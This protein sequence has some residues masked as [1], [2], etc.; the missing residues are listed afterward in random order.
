M[1]HVRAGCGGRLFAT[2]LAV[3][4]HYLLHQLLDHL[5]ADNAILLTRQFCDCFCDCVDHLVGFSGINFVSEPAVAGCS[6]KKS[7]ISST[8]IQWRQ[9]ALDLV[10]TWM[11]RATPLRH[12]TDGTLDERKASFHVPSV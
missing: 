2:K 1:L 4:M 7:S 8:I 6:A 5:L 3:L 9:G 10:L 12:H 11:L